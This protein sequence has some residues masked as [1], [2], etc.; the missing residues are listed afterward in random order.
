MSDL[1]KNLCY[2]NGQWVGTPE[3]A[4]TNPANDEEIVK[5]PNLGAAE[6]RDA[7]A[8][9]KEAMAAATLVQRN[10]R[11]PLQTNG[12]FSAQSPQMYFL[13]QEW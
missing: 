3:T 2:I 8:A 1:R 6:T 4:I 7:I 13:Q 9:A 11:Q 12:F 10:N 5:V